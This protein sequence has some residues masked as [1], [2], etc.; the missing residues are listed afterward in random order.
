MKFMI[1]VITIGRDLPDFLGASCSGSLRVNVSSSEGWEEVASYHCFWSQRDSC[2]CCDWFSRLLGCLLGIIKD[3]LLPSP[4]FL[5]V[6]ILG[7]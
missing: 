7:R 4:Y 5:E 3:M 6:V 1:E 2:G